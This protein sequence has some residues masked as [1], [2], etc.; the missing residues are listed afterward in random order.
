MN[1]EEKKEVLT[2]FRIHGL[3]H[4][5]RGIAKDNTGKMHFI[6]NA[7]PG[8][9]VQTQILN[10]HKNYTESIALSIEEAHPQR[11]LAPCDYYLDCGGCR[12]QHIQPETQIVIKEKALYERLAHANLINPSTQILPALKG[13]S[14]LSYRYKARLH[15]FYSPIQK[16]MILG[17]RSLK[18]P[19]MI[20]PIKNCIIL[21]PCLNELLAPVTEMLG[22]LSNFQSINH[23]TFISSEV[24]QLDS[25]RAIVFEYHFP[26][27]KVDLKRLEQF[28]LLHKVAIYFLANGMKSVKLLSDQPNHE[29]YYTLAKYQLRLNFEVNDFVQVNFP[30]NEMMVEQAIKLLEINRKD[31]VLDCYCGIGNFSLPAARFA[32]SVLGLEGNNTSIHQAKKNAQL[33]HIKNIEN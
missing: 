17:F 9:L 18:N 15:V 7:L 33:N 4:E 23:I 32:K 11:V 12:L 27:T 20:T 30:V 22:Q 19:A 6:Y 31:K 5:G 16:K 13:E 21:H 28:S 8:E 14:D 10:T 24:G 2:S 3:S 25:G 1:E 29:F 26:F